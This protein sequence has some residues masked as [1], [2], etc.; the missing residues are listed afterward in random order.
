MGGVENWGEG[1][2]I[3]GQRRGD[4]FCPDPEEGG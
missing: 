2:N 4:E 1:W 3:Y